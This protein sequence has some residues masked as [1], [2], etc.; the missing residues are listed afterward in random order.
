[1]SSKSGKTRS[2]FAR[3]LSSPTRAVRVD[4][5][6]VRQARE[7]KGLTQEELASLAGYSKRTIEKFEKG[8]KG[9]L[10]TIRDVAGALSV[11]PK[12][13]IDQSRDPRDQQ[14]F[15]RVTAE[16]PANAVGDEAVDS[17][18]AT[19]TIRDPDA[20]AEQR[21]RRSAAPYLVVGAAVEILSHSSL[22]AS[23]SINGKGWDPARVD[24][25]DTGRTFDSGPIMA[26]LSGGL[27]PLG[28][29]EANRTK[30]VLTGLSRPF[31]DDEENLKLWFSRT[32][33]QTHIAVRQSSDGVE[34]NDALA[35]EFGSLD[36]ELNRVPSA[37]GLHYV[38]RLADDKVILLQ[39]RAD[40]A[41]DP[42]TWSVSGEEQFEADDFR[43]GTLLRVFQRALCEE[44][45]GLYDRSPETL[46]NLWSEHIEDKL[47]TMKLWGFVFEEHACVTSLFGF[48]QFGLSVSAFAEWYIS[49]LNRGLG[50]RD[51]EG[52]LYFTTV[53][54]LGELLIKGQCAARPLFGKDHAVVNV[55][56]TMLQKTARY[57]V[58]RLF[59]ALRGRLP[60]Q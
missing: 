58:F 15:K 30:Y 50:N 29:N 46:Q 47:Q 53:D 10:K 48:Y 33:W 7:A 8:S 34:K 54:E 13:L 6:K 59:H 19:R 21:V 52:L 14:S 51:N 2:H 36:I 31:K 9:F 24:V 20:L 17:E 16:D 45:T 40:M 57:R 43:D 22:G 55:R 60:R 44:V 4:G 1:V 5:D 38:V 23:A 32:D 11:D 35:L 49:L 26:R 3:T 39:R 42:A 56:S 37:V 18:D 27:A 41:H 12:L 25:I 28:S